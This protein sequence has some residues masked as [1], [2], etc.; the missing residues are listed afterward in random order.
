MGYQKNVSVKDIAN[1][2]NISLSTVNKAL[3]GKPGISEKRRQEVIA[4]A[5]EMG[6]VVNT[7]A[8]GLSRKPIM[9]GVLIPSAWENYFHLMKDGFDAEFTKLAK[10][11]VQ[12]SYFNITS[13]GPGEVRNIMNWIEQSELDAVILC[14]SLHPA[15]G[16]I[17]HEISKKQLPVFV[18]GDDY[19]GNVEKTATTFITVDNKLSGN[20]AGDF[21]ENI[22]GR[23]IRAAVFIGSLES[24]SH[25]YKADAFIKRVGKAGAMSFGVYETHDDPQIA[26]QKMQK[27]YET[28]P[29]INS[30][31]VATATSEPICRFI[32]ENDLQSG[33]TVLGTDIFD[34][35]KEY[36]LRGVM[37]ATLY[38]KQEELGMIAVRT[39]FDYLTKRS[40]YS[41]LSWEAPKEILVKPVLYLRANIEE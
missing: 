22:Y 41:T 14:S 19:M 27:I 12:Y 23:E 39:A 24:Y 32:H 16:A 13:D 35:L 30:I 38:Q 7:A 33:I 34:A 11:K 36:M 31:Y 26:F 18:V 20:M 4:A 25:K 17:L 29:D 8:Q 5:L 9:I 6:Y 3:T 2:L 40:S 1:K 37:K 21:F 10:Y 15:N 28:H